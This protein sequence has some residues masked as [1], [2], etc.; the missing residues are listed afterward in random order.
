MPWK[1]RLAM[2]DDA[3]TS[4]VFRQ[5]ELAIVARDKIEVR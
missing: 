1:S 5:N 3:V 4:T 2:K